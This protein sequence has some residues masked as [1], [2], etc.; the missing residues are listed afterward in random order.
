MYIGL[1][2]HTIGAIVS[3]T[4]IVSSGRPRKRRE[5]VE[6]GKRIDG[7]VRPRWAR[8]LRLVESALE[9]KGLGRD[10]LAREIASN[11][12]DMQ[13]WP[14]AGVRRWIHGEV[15]ITTAAAYDVGEALKRLGVGTCGIEALYASGHIAAYIGALEYLAPAD[16]LLAA[17]LAVLPRLRWEIGAGL[18]KKFRRYVDEANNGMHVLL[19]RDYD[20]AAM[21]EAWDRF[22][23]RRPLPDESP[24]IVTDAYNVAGAPLIP[25]E[26]AERIALDLLGTWALELL[27]AGI[28]R[29]GLQRALDVWE[30]HVYRAL[31]ARR[32]Q[33]L[34]DRH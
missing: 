20:E 8:W 33:R 29:D 4:P 9:S 32:S 21:R 25:I 16:P 24:S 14:R 13:T 17:G 34:T 5:V 30:D 7:F 18:D 12:A 28:E 26:Q 19:E 6:R 23:E 2:W 27:P 22:R 11:P 10:D 15:T 1:V 3:K 31:L